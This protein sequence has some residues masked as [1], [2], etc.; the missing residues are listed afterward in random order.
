MSEKPESD[1]FD[2]DEADEAVDS[3]DPQLEHLI[4][5]L[6]SQKRRGG[7]RAGEPAWRRLEKYLEQKRTAELLSDFDDY[8]IGDA[9]DEGARPAK[10]RSAKKARR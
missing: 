8:D 6:E 4:K 3:D 7:V 5:D 1:E 10:A 2:E 9:A